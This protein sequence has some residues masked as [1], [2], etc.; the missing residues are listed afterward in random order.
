MNVPKN[1]T[2]H[3]VISLHACDI[4][5]DAVIAD[6]I[7]LGAKVILSTPC[8]HRNLSCKINARELSFVTEFPKL[9]EKLCE[10]LTDGLRLALLRSEGYDVMATELTDP[11]N[12]PKNTLLRAVYNGKRSDDARREYNEILK[13]LMGDNHEDY[14][15][16]F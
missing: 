9:S 16:K 15:P 8:C 6:A 1:E 5:T 7:E 10:A 12:T 2:V 13:F 3:L 14:L 4:A 11:E